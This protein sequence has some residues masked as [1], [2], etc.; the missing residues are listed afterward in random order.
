MEIRPV[1]AELFYANGGSEGQTDMIKLFEILPTR[2]KSHC[3]LVRLFY[4]YEALY[5]TGHPSTLSAPRQEEEKSQSFNNFNIRFPP[6][7]K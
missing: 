1:G 5:N 3:P 4:Q 2:L 6:R 7:C